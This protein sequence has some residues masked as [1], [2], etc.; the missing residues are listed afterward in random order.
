MELTRKQ[1]AL[2]FLL[3]FFNII[4]ESQERERDSNNFRIHKVLESSYETSFEFGRC[5]LNYLTIIGKWLSEN[6]PILDEK[7]LYIRDSI[8]FNEKIFEQ[9]KKI[10]PINIY[11]KGSLFDGND[12]Y[13]VDFA[14]MYIGGGVLEGGCVQ[15]EILFA[16]QPEAIVSM[17]LMEVMDDNDAI[18]IDNTIRYSEYTG[19]GRS[20]KFEK[21]A[22]DM[23]DLKT[24][25]RNKF[26]A[27]DA[28]VNYRTN[29]GMLDEESIKRDIH[30]AYV[31][32]SLINF[33]KEDGKHEEKSIATG[34]WDVE[35]LEA[36]MN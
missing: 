23:K 33:F 28:S 35:L 32:F 19:Y 9:K 13:F 12:S 16:V 29:F 11:E 31:G 10:C 1:V 24:I 6:N 18:R 17:F 8:E 25:K 20:V 30:K 5:F 4:D 26:I 22:I 2:I 14:N 3:S 21:S 36:I 7:I 34:N 27:I 15:E